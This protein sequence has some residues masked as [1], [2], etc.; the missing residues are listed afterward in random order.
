MML[1]CTQVTSSSSKLQ[2]ACVG[3]LGHLNLGQDQN[4]DECMI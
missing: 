1:A 2:P 3:Q 4:G